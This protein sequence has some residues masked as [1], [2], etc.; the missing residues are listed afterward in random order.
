M[1]VKPFSFAD[2]Q[3]YLGDRADTVFAHLGQL[4]AQ[5][6]TLGSNRD[7]YSTVG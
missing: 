4:E 2:T 7:Y 3:T 6:S 1:L 5:L